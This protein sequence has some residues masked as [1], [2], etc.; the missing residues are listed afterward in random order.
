MIFPHLLGVNLNW[1]NLFCYNGALSLYG[2]INL[3]RCTSS[4]SIQ[5]LSNQGHMHIL[6]PSNVLFTLLLFSITCFLYKLFNVLQMEQSIEVVIQ[7]IHGE[8]E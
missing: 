1:H 4:A 5:L 8:H 7:I 2:C 6:H 3:E